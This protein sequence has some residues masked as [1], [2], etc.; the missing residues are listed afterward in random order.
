MQTYFGHALARTRVQPILNGNDFYRRVPESEALQ[1]I[2]PSP[3][4][5]LTVGE[6]K[7]RKGQLL[8]LAAFARVKAQIPG[9]RYFLAGAYRQNGYFQKLQQFVAD[10][11]LEDVHFLGAVSEEELSHF[12]RQ[13]SVFLLTPQQEGLHF[14]GFGLVYLEAGAYGLPVVATRS[15]GVP[16]A[17]Q[18]GVTGF[19]AEPDDVEGLAGALVRLLGD[20]ELSRRMGR[21]NRR[22][23]E[24]LTWEK[25]AGEYLQAYQSVLG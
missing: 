19:L 11:K 17:V 23:A 7:P 13:A 3:P 12:Y 8:S 1:R 9:A 24:T 4:A 5:I 2:F 16:D 6:I 20:T 14:E 25:C 15:G 22:W 21:A 18:D 10:Q